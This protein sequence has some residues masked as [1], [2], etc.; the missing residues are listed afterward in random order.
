MQ[1]LRPAPSLGWESRGGPSHLSRVHIPRLASDGPA[2]P[3][4]PL[5]VSVFLC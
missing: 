2:P 3:S 1:I 4:L 5:S